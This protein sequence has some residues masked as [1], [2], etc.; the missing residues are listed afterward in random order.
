VPSAVAGRAVAD[1]DVDGTASGAAAA[2]QQA[3]AGAVVRDA[4]PASVVPGH[5]VAAVCSDPVVA[6]RAADPAGFCPA[7]AAVGRAADLAYLCLVAVVVERV[8]D[9]AGFCL[10]AVVAESAADLADS[11]PA[12]AVEG[13][14]LVVCPA[15]FRTCLALRACPV[16]RLVALASAFH[17]AAPA[18]RAERQG[19]PRSNARTAVLITQAGFMGVAFLSSNCCSSSAQ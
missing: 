10:A 1:P 7:P 15:A 18:A 5:A 14:Q 17:L 13:A 8:A 3:A 9:P 11:C 6:E 12:P 16:F 19:V 4:L 2:A